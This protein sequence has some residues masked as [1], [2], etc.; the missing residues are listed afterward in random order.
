V[1]ED[2]LR[3]DAVEPSSH[4]ELNKSAVKQAEI[5]RDRHKRSADRLKWVYGA[6]QAIAIVAAAGAT[7]VAVN[8]SWENDWIA[9]IPAAVATI[10]ATALATFRFQEHWLRCRR[11]ASDLSA[12]IALFEAAAGPYEVLENDDPDPRARRRSRFVAEW[13]R[14]SRAGDEIVEAATPDDAG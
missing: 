2:A 14:I 12:E 5:E 10:A 1:S 6:L 8:G 4:D 13:V 3:E 9:A 11:A 7:V